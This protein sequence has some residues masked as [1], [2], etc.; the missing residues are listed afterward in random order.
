MGCEHEVWRAHVNVIGRND[1][2]DMVAHRLADGRK[3]F[4]VLDLGRIRQIRKP[5][6]HSDMHNLSLT[7]LFITWESKTLAVNALRRRSFDR[8]PDVVWLMTTTISG[9]G[10]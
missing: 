6:H 5:V 4:D 3:A 10:Q 8:V 1:F 9:R 2:V 7:V